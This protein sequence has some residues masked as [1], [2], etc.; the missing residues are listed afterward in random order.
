MKVRLLFVLAL[1]LL[2]T[3]CATLTKDQVYAR[4]IVGSWIIS[5]DSSDNYAL[6]E[7]DVFMKNGTR[8]SYIYAN[9]S[10]SKIVGHVNSAWKVD[11]GILI[12]KITYDP[13]PNLVGKVVKLRIVSIGKNRMVLRSMD[14]RHAY[15]R[16]RS[17]DCLALPAP[18]ARSSSRAAAA[19]SNWYASLALFNYVNRTAGNCQA[20]VVESLLDRGA[21]PNASNTTGQHKSW[22]FSVLNIAAASGANA[23]ALELIR[24]GANVSNASHDALGA[25]AL[26]YAVGANHCAPALVEALIA[27]GANVNGPTG[28]PSALT[29]IEAALVSSLNCNID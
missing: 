17:T 24:H 13:L 18:V 27:H 4:E 20:P 16:K 15:F 14:G 28:R 21:S 7:L 10:C 8:K 29:P 26:Q 22:G 9:A 3:G 19:S 1:L 6:P 5:S 11:N 23:C 2:V 12:S 25:S